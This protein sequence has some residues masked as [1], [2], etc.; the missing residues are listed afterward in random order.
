METGA[1]HG[2]GAEHPTLPASLQEKKEGEACIAEVY[3][4]WLH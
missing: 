1:R 4:M 3:T 2:V